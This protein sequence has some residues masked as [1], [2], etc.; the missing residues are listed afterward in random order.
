MPWPQSAAPYL[1][2][3]RARDRVGH[4]RTAWCADYW[5]G[6]ARPWGGGGEVIYTFTAVRN[7]QK[8]RKN[9]RFRTRFGL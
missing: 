2:L 1:H 3:E 5:R 9:G 4:S 8:R 6:S 7:N